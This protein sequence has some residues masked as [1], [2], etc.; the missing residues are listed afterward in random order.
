MKAFIVRFIITMLIRILVK[1]GVKQALL[2]I[3]DR[4]ANTTNNNFKRKGIAVRMLKELLG[5]DTS[6]GLINLLIELA[7][8]YRKVNPK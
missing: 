8:M 6:T 5:L 4:A 7:V 2:Q 1:S 3:I